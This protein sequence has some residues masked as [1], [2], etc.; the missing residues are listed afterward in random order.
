MVFSV[1]YYLET[2]KCNISGL[3]TFLVILL[4]TSIFTHKIWLGY[5]DII[6]HKQIFLVKFHI[7]NK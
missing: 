1:T 3:L 6:E 5:S 2:T 7:L 4:L